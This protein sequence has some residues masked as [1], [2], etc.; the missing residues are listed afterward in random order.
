MFTHFEQLR[1][2][3]F[4]TLTK[5]SVI[6]P[7]GVSKILSLQ[8]PPKKKL[9]PYHKYLRKPVMSQKNYYISNAVSILHGS[10]FVKTLP[11]R[12]RASI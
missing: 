2:F 12:S 1:Y 5:L 4:Y 11:L 6:L 7:H 8:G 3:D 10:I 9:L